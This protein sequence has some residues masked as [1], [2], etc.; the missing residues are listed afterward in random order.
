MASTFFLLYKKKKIKIKARLD[1]IDFEA[2][3]AQ[4]K[5]MDNYMEQCS[6]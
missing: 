1:V 6:G 2:I 3:V 4:A 5:E